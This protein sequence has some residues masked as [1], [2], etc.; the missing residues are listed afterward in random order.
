M[1]AARMSAMELFGELK[2][3]GAVTL[4][5]IQAKVLHN[6][7]ESYLERRKRLQLLRELH[8]RLFGT[9][10]GD[11]SYG[12]GTRVVEPV[13]MLRFGTIRGGAVEWKGEVP[14]SEWQAGDWVTVDGHLGIVQADGLVE[15]FHTVPEKI[16]GIGVT[17]IGVEKDKLKLR[18]GD[19]T[20]SDMHAEGTGKQ[21]LSVSRR[22]EDSRL[23]VAFIPTPL[24]W[25]FPAGC[26]MR[27]E[28]FELWA[29]HAETDPR[30]TKRRFEAICS[31]S[32]ISSLLSRA[33]LKS[34][35]RT[36]IGTLA[37]LATMVAA[38]R[39]RRA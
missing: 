29:K 36:P 8:R 32:P 35:W 27:R 15:T 5:S 4:Q 6:K 39:R 21:V 16:R 31:G 14:Y 13:H 25:L 11:T 18:T 28:D 33:Y 30:K 12:D 26:S 38:A 10:F 20:T 34:D 22:I 19:G 17:S 1:D 9:A 23:E 3:E 2:S 24:H 37:V 7:D